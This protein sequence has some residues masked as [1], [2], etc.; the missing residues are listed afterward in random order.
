MKIEKFILNILKKIESLQDGI[1]AYAYKSSN[2][3][4]TNIW[5][6]ISISSFEVYMHNKR[7][8]TLS[9]AWC[10]AAQLHGY[11][12]VFVCGFMP[13]EVKLMRLAERDNLILNV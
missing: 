12:I 5:W 11:K 9:R 1:I 10:K 13:T 3:T 2:E 8:K 6:E 4:F 7:F